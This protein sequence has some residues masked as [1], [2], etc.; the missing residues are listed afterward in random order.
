MRVEWDKQSKHILGKH[1]YQPGKSIF[2]HQDPQR[3]L[4]EFAGTGRKINDTLPGTPGYKEVVDFQEHIGIWK[5][6]NGV[7]LPTTRG[8][9]HYS[10][11]GAHIVPLKPK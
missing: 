6:E 7:A 2:E 8:A 3:L 9:I 1:N 10:K 5:N 4:E 11:N